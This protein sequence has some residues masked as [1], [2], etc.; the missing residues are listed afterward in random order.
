MK[1]ANR[2]GGGLAGG[3]VLV[4]FP[5]LWVGQIKFVFLGGF[6]LVTCPPPTS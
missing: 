2:G 5:L 1:V 3:W 6:C 4:L